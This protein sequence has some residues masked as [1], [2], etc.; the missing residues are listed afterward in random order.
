MP[1]RWLHNACKSSNIHFS[2]NSKARKFWNPKCVLSFTYYCWCTFVILFSKIP[3]PDRSERGGAANCVLLLVFVV[4]QLLLQ[5]HLLL[6]H[7]LCQLHV[8]TA[9]GVTTEP[10]SDW[11]RSARK[12]RRLEIAGADPTQDVFESLFNKEKLAHE[13]RNC[14]Y[15]SLVWLGV[16]HILMNTNI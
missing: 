13:M 8:S 10:P 5:L 6:Q 7:A 12:R 16:E 9:A 4:L 11:S 14:C 15:S 1:S 2:W 3:L